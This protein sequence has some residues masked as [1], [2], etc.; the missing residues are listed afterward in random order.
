LPFSTLIAGSRL[1]ASGLNIS[2]RSG[3]F[4][5]GAAPQKAVAWQSG[6]VAGPRRSASHSIAPAIRSKNPLWVL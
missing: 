6:V 3:L 5:P 4:A 2:W 1:T